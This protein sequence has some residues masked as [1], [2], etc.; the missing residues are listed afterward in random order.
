MVKKLAKVGNSPGVVV[1]KPS[2]ELLKISPE[3]ALEMTTDGARIILPPVRRRAG[4]GRGPQGD[5]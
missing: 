4:A 1:D 5:A 2:L 3:T